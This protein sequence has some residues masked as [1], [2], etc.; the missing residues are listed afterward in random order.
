MK[1]RVMTAAILLITLVP[2]VIVGG[3]FLDV[4]LALLSMGAT[5]EL[6]KMYKGEEF[7][8]NCILI[9]E[10]I[11]SVA[12]FFSV[13]YYLKGTLDLEYLFIL[14]LFIIFSAGI[15]LIFKEDFTA[16]DFGRLFVSVLYPAIGFAALSWLRDIDIYNIGFLFMITIFTDV[17]AY[18]VGVN[19]GKHRLSVKISPKKSV[20]G[21]IGGTVAALLLTMLYLY[22][23]EMDVVGEIELNILSSILLIVFISIIGQIGDLIASKLK[24]GFDIKD[25]SQIFPGHGGI[26]DR[27]DSAIF[28]AITLVLISKVVGIL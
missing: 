12:I 28:A 25:F 1:V 23:L 18:I 26:M 13:A 19:Y 9:I 6:F 8:V 7:K 24:R 20:E 14:V 5:Y 22:L 10:L 15:A 3:L 21:S 17:F 16:E 4:V 27:F 2:L 11:L